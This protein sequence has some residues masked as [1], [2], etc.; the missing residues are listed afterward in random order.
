MYDIIRQLIAGHSVRATAKARQ[1][2]SEVN[3]AIHRWAS[4]AI[5]DKTRKHTLALELARLDE[6][7]ETFYARALEGVYSVARW[8][9]SARLAHAADSSSANRRG[10]EAKG[11]KHR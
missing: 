9:S 1:T 5:P 8:S 6:L 7:Q 2:V 11:S 4:S 10:C 3:A